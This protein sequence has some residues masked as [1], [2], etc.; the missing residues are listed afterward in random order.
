MGDFTKICIAV[1]ISNTIRVL[2]FI[3]LAMFFNA[4]WMALLS[5]L[6]LTSYPDKD[7]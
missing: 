2:G 6:F 1:T 3:A 4:W 7:A 5:V